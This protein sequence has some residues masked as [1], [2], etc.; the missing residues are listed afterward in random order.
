MR[1]SQ[2]QEQVV[3]LATLYGWK[4]FH[5]YDSRRTDPGWPDL[6]LV[7]VPELLAVELKTQRGRLSPA[8][9]QWIHDLMD[10]GIETYVWRPS[11]FDAIHER[12]KRLTPGA[13]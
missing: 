11:H 10:C 5:V 13:T 9:E 12:L 7:R 4:H 3:E 6:I 1:E 8:Q 2:F